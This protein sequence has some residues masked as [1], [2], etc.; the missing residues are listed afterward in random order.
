MTKPA[1]LELTVA[2]D[3]SDRWAIVR[4]QGARSSC[5]ACAVSD[6]HMH[7]QNLAHLLSVEYLF[8][9]AARL[10]HGCDV[11]RGLTFGAAQAALR[12]HGQPSEEEWPYHLVEP[13]PWVP[14]SVTKI[15]STKLA[16]DLSKQITTITSTIEI[17]QPVILGVQLTNDF[18]N[19]RSPSYIISPTGR[20]FGGHAVLGVGFAK[21]KEGAAH[22]LIRN[23]W[24]VAWGDG[25]HAWLPSQY[26]EDKLIG[27]CL[28][29]P[30]TNN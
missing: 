25:G 20:G 1:P 6:A 26:L 16:I 15:W 4:D 18:F 3:F 10:M 12:N 24:G 19:V 30:S 8:F 28:T 29:L 17:G 5:L 7:A 14:P 21:D 23:S 2:S 27:F 11:S 13:N 22:L 9:H